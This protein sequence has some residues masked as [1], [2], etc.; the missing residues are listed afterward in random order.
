MSSK[1]SQQRRLSTN[2]RASLRYFNLLLSMSF[3]SSALV[4]AGLSPTK[5]AHLLVYFLVDD[6]ISSDGV[7][8]STRL[9]LTCCAAISTYLWA[10]IW[11]SR[12][13]RCSSNSLTNVWSTSPRSLLPFSISRTDRVATV[14]RAFSI[15]RFKSQTSVGSAPRS[16]FGSCGLSSATSWTFAE[17]TS[18]MHVLDILLIIRRCV[19]RFSSTTLLSPPM[20]MKRSENGVTYASKSFGLS[21]SGYL[22]DKNSCGLMKIA[23]AHLMECSKATWTSFFK[24]VRCPSIF[25]FTFWRPIIDAHSLYG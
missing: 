25:V 2:R 15:F 6:F 9:A 23:L 16:L 17:C 8:Q 12:A 11:L 10:C 7:W 21:R 13:C 20:F 22:G 3:V 4:A 5:T 14:P 18:A 1:T 19:S 24:V